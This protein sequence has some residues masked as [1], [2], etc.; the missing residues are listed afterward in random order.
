MLIAALFDTS[1]VRAVLAFVCQS[2]KPEVSRI[3]KR[4]LSQIDHTWTVQTQRPDCFGDLRLCHTWTNHSLGRKNPLKDELERIQMFKEVL[5]GSEE[6]MHA[7][8][9]EGWPRPIN[10]IVKSEIRR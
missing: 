2:E 7:S 3:Q 4:K 10:H 1:N 5:K 8:C 9:L 6:Q